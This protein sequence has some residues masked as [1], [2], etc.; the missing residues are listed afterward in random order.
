MLLKLEC[1]QLL[2]YVA[3]HQGVHK[4]TDKFGTY[5]FLNEVAVL[6]EVSL[7]KLTSV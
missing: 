3:G 2:R 1:P 6:L 7:R 4:T 5:F